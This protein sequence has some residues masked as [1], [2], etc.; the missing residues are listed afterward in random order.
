MEVQDLVLQT[1]KTLRKEPNDA[2]NRRPAQLVLHEL[3][4][5]IDVLILEPDDEIAAPLG[6]MQAFTPDDSGE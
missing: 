3:K 4:T 6:K 2:T 1:E 5:R